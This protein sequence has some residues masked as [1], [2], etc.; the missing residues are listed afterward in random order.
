MFDRFKRI[1]GQTVVVYF[2]GITGISD[3]VN[4]REAQIKE[5]NS[6]GLKKKCCPMSL[7]IFWSSVWNLLY[8]AI[9]VVL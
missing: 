2:K 5:A 3:I 6:S 1:S 7:F 9:C 8:V 4:G